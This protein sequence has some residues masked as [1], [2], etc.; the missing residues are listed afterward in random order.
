MANYQYSS[1]YVT[2]LLGN[3]NGDFPGDRQLRRGIASSIRGGGRFQRRRQTRPRRGE[4]LASDTCR[5]LLGNGN[6][7]FPAAVN[8]AAGRFLHSVAVGDFNGDGK[9]DSRRGELW[10]RPTC[11]CCCGNGSGSFLAAVNYAAADRLPLRGGGRFQRRR[12]TRPRRGE[13]SLSWQRVACCWATADGS[14]PAAVN[15]A[16]RRHVSLLRGGGRLQRR[17]QA[18]PRRGEP[19][20]A[21]VSVLLGNG[22]GGFPAAVNYAAGGRLPAPWRWA[23]STATASPTWPWRTIGHRPPCQR[24]AGQRQRRLRRP[25]ST[26][27]RRLD[28]YS[29]A[30][31]DFNGD[32]KPD[33]AVAN[34]DSATS[35]VLLGNG[36]GT[37]AAAVNYAAGIGSSIRGGGRFQRRRQA[38]PGRGEL[39]A[40]VSVLLN[41]GTAASWP[42]SPTPR[43]SAPR[44]VAAGDFNGDGKPDLAVANSGSAPV[45]TV[46]V[47]LNNGNGGFLA[48]SQ[49][50]RGVG[51][52]LRGG[53]RFQRRRQARPGRGE[54]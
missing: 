53:G 12:Q 9:P 34:A 4:L 28:P 36:D 38:R 13:P 42:P 10:H 30:V 40:N 45:A 35:S 24:A 3:G 52:S 48:R 29:V 44:S 54:L 6:G 46:S 25:A 21:N 27:P 18:R 39:T 22:N 31:G 41:N 19:R 20:P 49:L 7:S 8:Y 16:S 26:T 37:F 33:L 32:G 43:G 1:G 51:S 5:V 17:R 2:V 15:Y 50:R 47:L 11:R 14:F 23:I